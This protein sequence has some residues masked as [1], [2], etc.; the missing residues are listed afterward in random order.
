MQ[1]H[2][3]ASD[4]GG[5]S[6]PPVSRTDPGDLAV[7]TRDRPARIGIDARP[8]RLPGIG[9]YL[10]E[11]IGQLADLDT[12][13]R[14]FVYCGNEK[15]A[16]RFRGRWP[17]VQVT[18]LSSGIYS[19]GEQ[20]QLPLRILR[21]RLDL[22]HAPT[23]LVV[24][25]VRS[26]PLVV[27]V[28]DLLLR[29][30]PENLPSRLARIYFTIMN[31]VALR[32][33][34]QVLTVSDFTR[35]E[36]VAAYPQYAGKA[37]TTHNAAGPAF[38][39]ARDD[40][41]ITRLRQQLGLRNRY[42]LYVGTY[43]KHKNLPFLIEAYAALALELRASCQLLLIAPRDPRYPEVDA[44]IARHRLHR[45]IVQVDHVD[46]DDLIALYGSAEAVV[47]P[48][49]YEGFG[50]PVLEGMACRTAVIATRIPAFVEVA[51]D[52]ALFAGT[53]DR[54]GMTAAL[55]RILGDPVLRI[56]LAAAGH[57]RST[58]FSW[59]NTARATLAAY[60]TALSRAKP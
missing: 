20:L 4:F 33:S 29:N 48:S 15:A 35:D 18:L 25:I 37:R 44:Q 24:P 60:R 27:T 57:E 7:G 13:D 51:G 17:H 47:A 46:E 11:L 6:G 2:A 32:W 22:F 23:S 36:L 45:D 55:A 42:F 58:R 49:I 56:R 43:K 1:R 40:G 59:R 41:R 19:V 14:F 26:C 52:C 10:S 3:A 12:I 34:R 28:H 50:F 54:P 39:P 8:L 38:Q 30:H 31:E 21:D 5:A 9:R 16:A 53:D